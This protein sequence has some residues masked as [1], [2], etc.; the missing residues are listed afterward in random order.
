MPA[1]SKAMVS[2][3]WPTAATMMSAGMRTSGASAFW[4]TGRPE[5]MA[6]GIWGWTQRAAARPSSPASM[7]TGAMRVSSST[8]SATAPSTSAGRAVMST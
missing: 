3:P 8:P 4:G 6:P 5:R 7:R 1:C 2:M